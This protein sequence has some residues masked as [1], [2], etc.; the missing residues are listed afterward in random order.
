MHTYIHY[1]ITITAP[2]MM[3][4]FY[5]WAFITFSELTFFIPSYQSKWNNLSYKSSYKWVP[6]KTKSTFPAIYYQSFNFVAPICENNTA[7]LPFIYFFSLLCITKSISWKEIL[8]RS[9]DINASDSQWLFKRNTKSGNS[10]RIIYFYGVFIKNNAFLFNVN[11]LRSR[12]E[13]DSGKDHIFDLLLPLERFYNDWILFL[14]VLRFWVGDIKFVNCCF[15][16]A[17]GE[18]LHSLLCQEKL[19]PILG[20]GK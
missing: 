5:K 16:V 3:G 10:T 13:V 2:L 18:L 17:W 7:I 9:L 8:R 14:I 19:L 20:S 12:G 11:G 4:L 6:S 15:Y 1:F